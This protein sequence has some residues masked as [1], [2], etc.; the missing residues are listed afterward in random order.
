MTTLNASK[1]DVCQVKIE[2]TD[3][4]LQ[5]LV[6]L[7]SP[8]FAEAARVLAGKLVEKHGANDPALVDDAFRRLTSRLPDASKAKPEQT[9][10]DYLFHSGR[11]E[12]SKWIERHAAAVGVA[13]TAE[14]AS[15]LADLKS[16]TSS[17]ASDAIDTDA[18]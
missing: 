14:L 2:R 7:N 5:G 13:D 10:L 18:A 17:A 4:P 8:Q 12:A 16:H 9:I 1:R 15:R 6:M 11:T 3:S